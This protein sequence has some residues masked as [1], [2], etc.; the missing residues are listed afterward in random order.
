M[1][2]AN[3]GID[4]NGFIVSGTQVVFPQELIGIFGQDEGI[5]QGTGT[6]LNVTGQRAIISLS[7][8]VLNLNISPD[9]F[10]NIGIMAW[11]EGVP[12]GTGTILNFVGSPVDVSIS[13]SVLR[14]FI[15]GSPGA[16][17]IPGSPGALGLFAKNNGVNLGTG[18]TI[19]F[20]PE[21]NAAITGTTIF[22]RPMDA[23]TNGDMWIKN[24]GSIQ[25]AGWVNRDY[26]IQFFLG[27]GANVISTGSVSAGYG[28]VDVPYDSIIES[29]S[30]V[31]DATGSVVVDILKSIYAGFPPS[32]PLAGLGQPVLSNKRTNTGNATGTV[33]VLKTDQLLLSV[34]SVS[35]IKLATVSLRGKGN[36]TS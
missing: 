12:I 13:G 17:G 31:A 19:D 24:T 22:V 8:T 25:Q 1:A 36:A 35:T 21:L 3:L 14:V 33:S 5:N 10:D 29:W 28:Y 9:P 20:G 23:G 15:T 7:G 27:D 6:I 4:S 32:S 26:N 30:V 34:S 18:T 2:V 11:D 16:Q